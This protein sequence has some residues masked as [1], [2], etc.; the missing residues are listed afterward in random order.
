MSR[1]TALSLLALATALEPALL[2]AEGD[3]GGQEAEAK[4][5]LEHFERYKRRF[6]LA[7]ENEKKRPCG[8]IPEGGAVDLALASLDKEIS[9]KFTAC[10]FEAKI[11]TAPASWKPRD[12]EKGWYEWAGSFGARS[13]VFANEIS[14][15]PALG[16][17]E[18]N[19]LL[20][21]V[22]SVGLFYHELLHGQ[23]LIYAM[24]EEKQA[25]WQRRFCA[26]AKEEDPDFDWGA[27]SYG[28]EEGQ[29]PK[30]IELQQAFED[31]LFACVKDFAHGKSKSALDLKQ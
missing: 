8:L 7:L 31:K 6:R 14:F 21:Q 1:L 15:D 19:S 10:P 22:Q 28:G 30:I 16:E 2:F 29:H 9:I 26:M 3:E 13:A 27:P 12:D 23:F 18:A 25:A 20:D 11:R 4:A 17:A 5:Q 24:Q